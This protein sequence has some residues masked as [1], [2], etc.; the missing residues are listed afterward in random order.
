MNDVKCKDISF[1]IHICSWNSDISVSKTV[2]NPPK[3][4]FLTKFLRSCQ[5]N[6][7]HHTVMIHDLHGH[8]AHQGTL[9]VTQ[10]V[11]ALVKP[12][13]TFDK[14]RVAKCPEFWEKHW[15]TKHVWIWMLLWNH[16]RCHIDCCWGFLSK[17]ES[18]CFSQ[19][20]HFHHLWGSQTNTPSPTSCKDAK[21]QLI[22]KVIHQSAKIPLVN[23]E[24]S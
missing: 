10:Q 3:S 19:N 1:N 21:E 22:W 4:C 18:F 8:T 24:S 15:K 12:R 20:V 5:R 6:E 13:R 9:R 2:L 7:V 11:V 17:V 23:L 14:N 16:G